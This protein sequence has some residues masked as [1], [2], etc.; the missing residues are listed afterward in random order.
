MGLREGTLERFTRGVL[1][2][3]GRGNI[4]CMDGGACAGAA[5]SGNGYP[6][7]DIADGGSGG[8]STIQILQTQFDP[9]GN[10]YHAKVLNLLTK[11]TYWIVSTIE[12]NA[13]LLEVLEDAMKKKERE[14]VE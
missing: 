9:Y 5:W 3:A 1:Q 12:D 14:V 7:S 13:I 2:V 11:E 8:M 6:I 10:V 4:T